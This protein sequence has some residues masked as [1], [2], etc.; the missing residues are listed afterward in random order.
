M[1]G[2]AASFN[3]KVTMCGLTGFLH[4]S[5]FSADWAR[6]IVEMMA[7]QISH[8]GPDDWGVW[9][10]ETAGLAMAHRR[11]SI[12]D[13]SIAGHQPMASSSGRFVIV[14]NGEIYN[15]MDLR[16]ELTAQ[17]WR[18]HSDTETLLSGFE[19][20]GIANTLEKT[21]GMFAF[22]LWDRTERILT[23][24]RDRMGEK[25]LYFGWNRG[26]FLFASELKALRVYPGFEVEFNRN[27]FTLFLRHSCIPTPYAIYRGIFKLWPGTMLTVRQEGCG[28][29]PWDIDCPPLESFHSNGV[30][31]RPYW[32][33]RDVAEQG[34]AHPFT[35]AENGA[36]DAL[37]RVLTTAVQSQQISDVPLGALL[38]GGVD[39]STIVALM[40]SQSSRPVKT[41]TIGFHEGDYNEAEY[42]N[43]VA[44]HLGTEHTELY[45]TTDDAL[46]VIPRLP[47]LYDEPFSDVAQIPTFLVSQLARQHV[48]VALS[49]D[50]G[51]E[52]FGGYNRYLLTSAIWRKTGWLPIKCRRA[53]TRGIRS[54]SPA[55]WNQLY[56]LAAPAIPNKMRITQA[57][58]KTHKLAEILDANSQESIYNRLLS[59]W[60]SPDDIVIG[61]HESP[62]VLTNGN[63]LTK[64]AQF[65]HQMM[66]LDAISYLPDDIL[67][68][69]DRAAMGVSLET[70]VPFLDHRVVE[71]AW[72]MPLGLKIRNGRGKWILRQVLYKYVPKK[73]I[74]RP[75]A[76]FGVPIDSWLRGPLREWAEALLAE[77]RLKR[78]GFFYPEP[79]RQKWHEHLSGQ[80]NW[81]YH[82]WDVLMFQAWLE[83]QR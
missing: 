55:R 63:N 74:E 1:G 44:R 49:G 28:I 4:P 51:D 15:H 69:V 54:V 53:L 42:A 19:E 75:K 13:L 29:C 83:A 52:L 79:I 23:L 62:T 12:L 64:V 20:W 35:G 61:G 65:E 16:E 26:L 6:A 71:F 25:P 5:G 32:S 80:R 7:Q 37:E 41:F 33:L 72:R 39:S 11:L 68:K 60:K 59:H 50:A 58:D 77:D 48:S 43:D 22:A 45:V 30:S 2:R 3:G 82:L 18:G 21:V 8:R 17:V 56:S 66:Y 40:Q 9:T 70:R 34:L 78:E 76:G 67:V 27:A 57:G 81:Q 73:L 36:V 47:T 14:F 31:L 10:D 38:S 46:A 24:A